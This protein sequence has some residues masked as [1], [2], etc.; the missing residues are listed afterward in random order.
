[1]NWLL[2]A[3]WDILVFLNHTRKTFWYYI[4]IDL[5]SGLLFSLT[6]NSVRMQFWK[7]LQWNQRQNIKVRSVLDFVNPEIRAEILFQIVTYWLKGEIVS[8][9]IVSQ[10]Q[11]LQSSA[12]CRLW[13]LRWHIVRFPTQV[14]WF[15]TNVCHNNVCQREGD[16][17]AMRTLGQST[18]VLT[19]NGCQQ[20]LLLL[21]G[22]LTKYELFLDRQS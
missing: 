22:L 17:E 8:P 10:N 6:S 16:L 20:F 13:H 4:L 18:S 15:D 9:Q 12:K 1:M 3:T 21:V 14:R 7:N 11:T 19:S 5:A 2:G